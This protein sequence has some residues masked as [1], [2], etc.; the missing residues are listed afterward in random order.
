MLFDETVGDDVLQTVGLRVRDE[1]VYAWNIVPLLTVPSPPHG[2]VVIHLVPSMQKH[3]IS[4][5]LSERIKLMA[6][7]VRDVAEGAQ[8]AKHVDEESG[9]PVIGLRRHR[10]R[11]TGVDD[12]R[13][14]DGDK[15]PSRCGL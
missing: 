8:V 1:R 14:V 11:D 6:L 12:A 2:L 13:G 5:A 9:R 10:A 3:Q 4:L 15:A 7:L